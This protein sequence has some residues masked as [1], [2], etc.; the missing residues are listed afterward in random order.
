M[1]VIVEPLMSIWTDFIKQV[2]QD[3]ITKGLEENKKLIVEKI[4]ETKSIGALN[5]NN[6]D[7]R[8]NSEDMDAED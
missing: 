6:Q 1:E 7:I 8:D 5:G 3:V 4:E 2:K